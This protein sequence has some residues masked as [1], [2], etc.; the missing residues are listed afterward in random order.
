MKRSYVPQVKQ[1]KIMIPG[2]LLTFLKSDGISR[3]SRKGRYI[4]Q[5]KRGDTDIPL[6]Y[7]TFFPH[8]GNQIDEDKVEIDTANLHLIDRPMTNEFDYQIPIPLHYTFRHLKDKEL[9]E[10]AIKKTARLL[11]GSGKRIEIQQHFAVGCTSTMP[12]YVQVSI[13]KQVKGFYVKAP[14]VQRMIGKILYSFVNNNTSA[15]NFLVNASII[16][17]EEIPSRPLSDFR[18][19]QLIH[20]SRAYVRHIVQAAAEADFMCLSDILG[21]TANHLID[22]E[23]KTVFCDFN[24]IFDVEQREN[25]IIVHDKE[26]NEFLQLCDLYC[27]TIDF[28]LRIPLV[29]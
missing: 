24:S 10:L 23:D 13:D 20:T 22:R 28:K 15:N 25:K 1:S 29:Y 7:A 17:E 8:I 9:F 4:Y 27:G 14:D 6:S 2:K 19:E 12:I 26:G 11:W 21:N 16:V 3:S 5:P 18:L